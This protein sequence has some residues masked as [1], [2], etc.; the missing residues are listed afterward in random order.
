MIS[1]DGPRGPCGGFAIA[2]IVA[3]AGCSD[4]R[5][6]A[7]RTD[8]VRQSGRTANVPNPVLMLTATAAFHHDSIPAAQ[9]AMAALAASTGEFTVTTTDDVSAITASELARSDVLFFALTSGE[10]PF[11]PAQKAAILDFVSAGG[12]FVGAHSATDTLYEWPDY[13]RLIGAYSASIPGRSRPT[14]IVEDPAHA[15]AAGLGGRFSILEEFY[16]FRENPRPGVHVVLRLDAE[17]VGASGDYPLA[18]SLPYGR[19]RAYSM[20][21]AISRAHGRIRGSRVRSRARSVGLHRARPERAR[22][23]RRTM[24]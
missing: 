1:V 7:G 18:W 2:L 12:G 11:T 13:G 6:A 21:S 8:A 16:T 22:R 17:S 14:S 3:A 5:P 4:R 19:G 23:G 20:R 15:S 24:S 9:Q 10:L